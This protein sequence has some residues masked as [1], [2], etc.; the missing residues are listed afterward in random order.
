M[1]GAHD[2]VLHVLAGPNGSGKTT[3]VERVLQPAT[4]L[5]FVNADV[6]AKQR[7]PRAA[8]EHSYEA[9]QLAA[10]ERAA[11]IGQGRSFLAETVFSHPSKVELLEVARAADYCITLHVLLIPVELAVAR[12]RDRV[13]KHGHEVP[14]DKVRGRYERLWALVAAA[15][16]IADDAI[17]YDNSAAATPFRPVCSFN[18]GHPV[19]PAVWP[20][21][22]P[23]DLRA[24]TGDL[25]RARRRPSS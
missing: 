11:L 9:A 22:T 5:P 3:L 15:I 20:S 12:V 16:R 21:W 4:G 7:W 17:V 14:E 13:A 18:H 1:T 8:A 23:E 10:A 2:P 25:L 6:I 24:A 19:R